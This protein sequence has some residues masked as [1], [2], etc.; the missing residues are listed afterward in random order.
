MYFYTSYQLQQ[1][2]SRVK[3]YINGGLGVI[4]S[5]TKSDN[6]VN[7]INNNNQSLLVKSGTNHVGLS[8]LAR[9]GADYYLTDQFQLFVDGGIGLS[10]INIGLA[11]TLK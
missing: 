6:T 11:I 4:S 7:F 3:P 9:V 5:R 8:L 10:I 2:A 1:N